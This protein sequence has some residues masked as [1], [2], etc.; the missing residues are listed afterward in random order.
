MAS[1]GAIPLRTFKT[2]L[3]PYEQ[4]LSHVTSR[5]SPKQTALAEISQTSSLL[6]HVTSSNLG[7]H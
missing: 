4:A 1:N 2:A 7:I 6:V 5:A 3:L